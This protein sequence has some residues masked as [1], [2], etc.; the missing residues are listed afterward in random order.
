VPGGGRDYYLNRSQPPFLSDMIVDLYSYNSSNVTTD[1]LDTLQTEYNFWM[2]S[3]RK[4]T[5]GLNFYS[6]STV[7]PRPEAYNKDE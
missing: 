6:S 1:M 3:E 7:L 5:S 2:S 4:R